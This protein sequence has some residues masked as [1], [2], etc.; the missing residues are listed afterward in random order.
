MNRKKMTESEMRD[1]LLALERLGLVENRER[2]DGVREYQMTPFAM[3]LEAEQPHLLEAILE[4]GSKE[5][6]DLSGGIY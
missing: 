2:S 4:R 3:K 6:M 5:E 1:A